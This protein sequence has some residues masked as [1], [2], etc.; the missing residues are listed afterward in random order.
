MRLKTVK[1]TMPGSGLLYLV[2]ILILAVLLTLWL[3]GEMDNRE[4]EYQ[5][6]ME[7][8]AYSWFNL[9]TMN[10]FALEEILSFPDD[11]NEAQ[12]DELLE[13]RLQFWKHEFQEPEILNRLIRVRYS[14][15][16]ITLFSDDSIIRM[17][18]WADHEFHEINDPAVEELA[19]KWCARTVLQEGLYLSESL[20]VDGPNP[21]FSYSAG[22]GILYLLEFDKDIF[23]RSFLERITRI[24]YQD[25][26]LYKMGL[27][28]AIVLPDKQN[29]LFFSLGGEGKPNSPYL[30][31]SLNESFSPYPQERVFPDNKEK[32]DEL[33][34]LRLDNSYYMAVW[35][36]RDQETMIHMD[37]ESDF[38]DSEKAEGIFFAYVPRRY[39]LKQLILIR[40]IPF[41]LIAYLS[42]FILGIALNRLIRYRHES[43][44]LIIHQEEFVS[45]MTH[46]LRTPIHIISS[47]AENMSDGIVKT[48]EDTIRYGETIKKEADRLSRMI[49][50]ILSYSGISRRKAEMQI[51]VM[52]DLIE[53]VL[54]PYLILC[55]EEGITLELDIQ[56][57]LRCRGDREAIKLI[58][59][60][61]LSNSIKYANSGRWIRV[62]LHYWDELVLTVEDRGPGVPKREQDEIF[63][64]FYRG[65]KNSGSSG[66]GLGLSI[67]RRIVENGGG[68]L[69][70]RSQEN[71]GC[72][73]SIYLPYPQIGETI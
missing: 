49:E 62:S 28:P 33:A 64:P 55:R 3:K 69:A 39:T 16:A 63:K 47:G 72:R 60:N 46:E 53:D 37:D 26:E 34:N 21:F 29:T 14:K 23:I 18:E 52:D 65:E 27:L 12:K 9:Y 7:E 1:N 70:F 38:L 51:L 5:R 67:V 57:G 6:I 17:E 10:L 8:K 61:L 68:K 42:L 50:S 40:I 11:L 45:S 25:N 19:E 54:A 24:V 20:D 66:N 31:I 32:Q 4:N 71:G 13:K 36:N 35:L 73:F 43:R 2:P 22:N 59:S 41:I 58:L 15:E 56:M 44:R 30:E 48:P